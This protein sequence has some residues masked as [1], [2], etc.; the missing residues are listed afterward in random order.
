MN[1]VEV[2]QIANTLT[3]PQRDVLLMLDGR[4]SALVLNGTYARVCKSLKEKGLVMVQRR[5]YQARYG[6]ISGGPYD[7]NRLRIYVLPTPKGADF[8]YHGG[9]DR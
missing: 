6:P 5:Y 3:K 7:T 9:L 4:T 1:T 8:I 2:N